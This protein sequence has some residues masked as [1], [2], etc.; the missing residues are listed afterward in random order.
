MKLIEQNMCLLFR[1]DAPNDLR[2]ANPALARAMQN[3]R[4]A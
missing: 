2:A 3:R 1:F 4:H